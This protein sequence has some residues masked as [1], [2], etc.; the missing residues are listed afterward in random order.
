MS[1]M[2]EGRPVVDV[3]GRTRSKLQTFH[4]EKQPSGIET[5][6]KLKNAARVQ[7]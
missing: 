7:T 4:E 1:L 6:R 5:K 2:S 3:F